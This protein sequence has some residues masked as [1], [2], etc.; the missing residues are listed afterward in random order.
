[1]AY[2]EPAFRYHQGSTR[3]QRQVIFV[4]K[5]EFC[6]EMDGYIRWIA[7]DLMQQE[8]VASLKDP[9]QLLKHLCKKSKTICNSM[10]ALQLLQF[11]KQNKG[12]SLSRYLL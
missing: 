1:M 10:K 2:V 11:S 5:W 9:S 8:V 7:T 3:V 6:C 12:P 4:S